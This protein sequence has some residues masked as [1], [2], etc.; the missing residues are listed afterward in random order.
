MKISKLLQMLFEKERWDKAIKKA[1]QKGI[2]DTTLK[3]LCDPQTRIDMYLNILNGNYEIMVFHIAEIPKDD[4]GIRKVW[5]AEAE[6]RVLL[7]IINDCLMEL[8]R[9]ILISK[10]CKSY[11][12]GISTQM[13]VLKTSN[14][15]AKLEKRFP[16]KQT[17]LKVDLRKYFDTVKIEVIDFIFNIIERMLGFEYGTEP[18]INVLRKLYHRNLV[19]NENGELV[20]LYGSLMQGCAISGFLADVVLYDIDEM[21]AKEFKYYV[22]YSDDMIILDEDIDKAEEILEKELPKYGVSLHPK[23]R[24]KKKSDEWIKFLGFYIKGERITLSETRLKKITKAIVQATIAKPFITPEQ[25]LTNIKRILYGYDLNGYS[26]A[27][28]CFHAMRN[29]DK[30]MIILDN[31]IKDCYRIVVIRHEYNQ[32]RKK[33]NLKPKSWSYGFQHIGGIG[34]EFNDDCIFKRGTGTKVGRANR[35]TEKWID[36]YLSLRCLMN[37]YKMHPSVFEACV[38]GMNM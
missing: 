25:A 8:F 9:D 38:R 27:T 5:V 34:I 15:M 14:T 4:G 12:S 18:V 20:E 3:K 6:D 35:E 17:T 26:F 31:F 2:N 16:D 7:S 33:N 23:K 24:E 30:D 32:K 19:F 29:N 10:Y 28:A 36:N 11:L 21:M 13:T 1:I 37:D 22:R